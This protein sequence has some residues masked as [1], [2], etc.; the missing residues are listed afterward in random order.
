MATVML[1]TF[2]GVATFWMQLFQW[3]SLFILGIDWPV[4]IRCE[5]LWSNWN[6][7]ESELHRLMAMKMS[8]CNNLVTLEIEVSKQQVT[9]VIHLISKFSL[10]RA[11]KDFRQISR[12]CCASIAEK[13]ARQI[14]IS[15]KVQLNRQLIH[16]FYA[17]LSSHHTVSH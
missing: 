1:A 3:G 12:T 15:G 13:F 8:H 9:I 7:W 14:T 6:S 16:C 11:M 5:L 10:R 2:Y 17:R 4:W